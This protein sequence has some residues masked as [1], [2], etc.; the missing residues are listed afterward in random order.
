MESS[1]IDLN[2]AG[3]D[4]ISFMLHTS[5]PTTINQIPEKKRALSN[6]SS[7]GFSYKSYCYSDD[8]TISG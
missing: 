8:Y 2:V 7:E 5:L 6:F 4:R 1:N 3:I